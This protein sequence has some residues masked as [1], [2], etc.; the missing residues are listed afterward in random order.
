VTDTQFSHKDGRINFEGAS[1]STELKPNSRG[2]TGTDDCH[3]YVAWSRC[4]PRES[5]WEDKVV[6]HLVC[7]PVCFGVPTTPMTMVNSS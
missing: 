3:A 2:G 7:G 1:S 5:G 4:Q 6:S